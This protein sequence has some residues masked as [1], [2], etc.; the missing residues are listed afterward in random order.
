MSAQSIRDPLGVIGE[1]A[2]RTLLRVLRV[3]YPH[4]AFPDG[5]YERARGAL[6]ADAAASP[7]LAGVIAQGVRDLDALAGRP[8]VDLSG[9]EAT[10]LL[11][12]IA[13]SDFFVA[14]RNKAFATL[15]DDHEVWGLLGYEG[16]SFEHGGYVERG[17]ADLD[18]LPEPP[19]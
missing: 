12:R 9:A 17:F 3:M 1:G 6:L 14:V 7:R 13:G 4:D 18:W 8:F 10:A 2:D 15:Y 11:E 5:P 16:P 19:L